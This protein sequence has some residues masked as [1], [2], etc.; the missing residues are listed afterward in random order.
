MT[1]FTNI[2]SVI[3]SRDIIERIEELETLIAEESTN[4]QFLE[5]CEE[6]DTLKTLAEECEQ[7]ASDWEYGETLIHRNYFEQYMDEMIEDCYELPKDLPYWMSIKL[8]Y[9]ALEQDYASVY[10]GDEEYLI[11]SC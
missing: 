6:Y 10:F 3:D 1:N 2:D 4:E 11:R 7:Y 8:D 9:D 5:W